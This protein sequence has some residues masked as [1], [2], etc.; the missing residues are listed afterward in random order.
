MA[1]PRDGPALKELASGHGTWGGYVDIKQSK[2][3][4]P[5]THGLLIRADTKADHPSTGQ[6]HACQFGQDGIRHGIGTIRACPMD[7]DK[8][9]GKCT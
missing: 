7:P 9:T 6:D 2:T 3:L 5:G 1:D 8:S 4:Q